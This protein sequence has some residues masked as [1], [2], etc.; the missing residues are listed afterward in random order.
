MP[1]NQSKSWAGSLAMLVGGFVFALAFVA[2]FNTLGDFNPPLALGPAAVKLA[3]IAL[4][5]AV[6]ESLPLG[7]ADNLTIALVGSALGLLL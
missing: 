5:A 7:E 3:L 2:L 6:V 1:F 4:A